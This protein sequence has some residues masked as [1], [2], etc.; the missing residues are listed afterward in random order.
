MSERRNNETTALLTAGEVAHI[1]KC[2]PRT[3]YRLS[4]SGQ[5]PQRLKVGSLVRW[6]RAEIEGW[7]DGGCQPL[8]T[9]K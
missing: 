8:R 2:S 4:D 7:V 6:K 5:M 1:L 9:K 3:V